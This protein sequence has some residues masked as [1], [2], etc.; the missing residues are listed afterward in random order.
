MSNG[1]TNGHFLGTCGG[2]ASKCAVFDPLSGT[3]WGMK[4]DINYNPFP[5]KTLRITQDGRYIIACVG[6]TD[7]VNAFKTIDGSAVPLAA[8]GDGTAYIT[9]TAISADGSRLALTD[10]NKIGIYAYPGFALISLIDLTTE[11]PGGFG[12]SP[13]VAFNADGSEFIIAST[14]SKKVH[15][16]K[17]DGTFR[18]KTSSI[19]NVRDVD[20]NAV[21]QEYVLVDNTAKLQAVNKDTGALTVKQTVGTAGNNYHGLH[22][23][24][25]GSK[26]LIDGSSMGS[27]GLYCINLADYAFIPISNP[28]GYNSNAFWN[29]NEE[30]Y[31]FSGFSSNG[32]VY[33]MKLENGAFS[34]PER[35]ATGFYTNGTSGGFILPG[36]VPSVYKVEVPIVDNADADEF[37][38]FALSLDLRIVYG[39]TD[40]P[41][42]ATSVDISLTTGEPCAVVVMDKDVGLRHSDKYY[43]AGELIFTGDT[44]YRYKCIQAGTTAQLAPNFPSSGTVTDGSA[45]FE[46]DGKLTHP[47]IN[48][49]VLPELDP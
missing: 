16:W 18:W 33:R 29:G 45:I 43:E 27:N 44:I 9:G 24:P 12:G 3:S 46:V 49:P 35:I 31:Q 11:E 7:N 2:V 21:A 37:R 36:G 14:S 26:M 6:R 28:G 22:I 34:A 38:A 10:R 48:A 39:V 40:V 17:T 20:F 8:I 4:L 30:V 1:A 41:A 13:L 47:I 32:G 42:G 25:D 23:S 19:L 15:C 5:D